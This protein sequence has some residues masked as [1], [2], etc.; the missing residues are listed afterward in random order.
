M[1]FRPPGTNLYLQIEASLEKTEISFKIDGLFPLTLPSKNKGRGIVSR[2]YL[3]SADASLK[4]RG[5]GIVQTFEKPYW[6]FTHP[7][8]KRGHATRTPVRLRGGEGGA[9]RDGRRL[10]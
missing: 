4:N 6:P 8:L 7:V 3:V 1:N 2:P 10:G 9:S 5:R